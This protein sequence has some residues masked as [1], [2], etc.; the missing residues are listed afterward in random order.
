MNAQG[1]MALKGWT[2]EA[3]L[4]A[5]EQYQRAFEIDPAFALAR[6]NF[7]LITALGTNTGLLPSESALADEAR[8]AAEQAIALDDGSSQVLGYAGCALSDLGDY[9]RGAEILTRA[10]EL[11]PSNA[12]AYVALGAAQCVSGES[13]TGI[14]NMRYG[15]RISP[16]DRRLGFWG[17]ALGSFLLRASRPIE[18]LQEARR[19][20]ARD[21]KLY[22]ARIL[23]AASL[24]SLGRPDEGR[25]AL[26]VARRL[27][28]TLT[29]QDVALSHGR[30]VSKLIEQLWDGQSI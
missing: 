17:W 11:D 2:E 13:E 30:Q 6:A 21:P 4:E 25:Q 22:L 14:E 1:A 7:A 20:A 26:R 18:A 29:A 5:R 3:I 10:V 12:Q 28:T 27:R 9:S 23:E 15:I 8:D 19:S 24:Q 16:R